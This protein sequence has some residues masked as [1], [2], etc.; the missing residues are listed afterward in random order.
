MATMDGHWLDWGA[1]SRA[2][3]GKEEWFLLKYNVVPRIVNCGQPEAIAMKGQ[4]QVQTR[5]MK[6]YRPEAWIPGV[7]NVVC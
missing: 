1:E 2:S 4:I 5:R 7:D 6:Q 3:P